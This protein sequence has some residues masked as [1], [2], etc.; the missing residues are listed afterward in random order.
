MQGE[1]PAASVRVST[2][3]L[4]NITIGV[5]SSDF[6]GNWARR[7]IYNRVESSPAGSWM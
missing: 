1:A 6:L 7:W 3:V 2:I 5:W 4:W